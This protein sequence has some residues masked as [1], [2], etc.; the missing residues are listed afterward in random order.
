M[1]LNKKGYMLIEI[2]LASALA[3]SVAYFLLKLTYKFKDKNESVYQA[4]DYIATKTLITKNIMNDLERGTISDFIKIDNSNY[5]LTLVLK[6][7]T[8]EYRRL[9]LR[10][11]NIVYGKTQDYN[12]TS[13]FIKN[14]VSYY[15]KKLPSSFKININ[16]IEYTNTNSFTK[17]NIPVDSLYS[18]DNY[19]IKLIARTSYNVAS[20]IKLGDYISYTPS[21][22]SYTINK[23]KTG[24]DDDTPQTI[25]PSELK[26]WRVIKINSNGTVEILSENISSTN[27]EFEGQTGYKNLIGYLNEL[28]K[29]YETTNI[30]V[31]SRHIG[32]NGQTETITNDSYFKAPAPWSCSTGQTCSPDPDDY[33]KDGG[34][35]TLYNADLNILDS[36]IGTRNAKRP[37]GVQVS[38]WISGRYFSHYSNTR[39]YW[40]GRYMLTSGSLGSNHLTGF[41]NGTLTKASRSF[42][43]RPIVTLKAGLDYS[44]EGT[45]SNPWKITN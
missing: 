45:E 2:I 14:D 42:A 37:S 16:K 3:F 11:N 26:V 33:E 7:G 1:K 40:I 13:S 38:Y 20:T 4:T 34:G 35:D 8:K 18:K 21:K 23:T 28:A 41:N 31:G 43:I 19:T 12:N 15:E 27:I 10:E 5:K 17:I 30:T 44:G 32:Y 39:H 36:I 22:T 29:Q 25:N 6:N 9:E 24:S